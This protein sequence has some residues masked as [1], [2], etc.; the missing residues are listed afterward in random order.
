MTEL[1]R[2][3]VMKLWLVGFLQDVWECDWQ[4]WKWLLVLP[5]AAIAWGSEEHKEGIWE[6]NK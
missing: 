1:R 3:S 5:T 4:Q 2:T 6:E